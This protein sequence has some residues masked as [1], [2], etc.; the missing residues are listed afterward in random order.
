M[1]EN[2]TKEWTGN[3]R[4]I[5]A[6]LGASNHADSERQQHDYYATEPKAVELLLAE[7]EFAPVIWEPACGE[8]H[9]SKVLEQHGYE[10]ISSDLIYRGYG[11]VKP[12]DFL[13]DTSVTNGDI[14]TTPP[15][16]NT[17]LNLWSERWRRCQQ[18]TRWR[19]FCDCNS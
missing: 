10:V 19:C 14:V 13:K 6:M 15:P 4:S 5:Y 1:N 18:D 16:I 17:L 11:D 3:Q 9:I 2:K 7:E 12:C 8:G